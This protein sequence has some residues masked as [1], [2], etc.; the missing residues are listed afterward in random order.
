M[1]INHDWYIY[2]KIII[3]ANKV[4]KMTCIKSKA[5]LKLLPAEPSDLL[6]DDMP[7]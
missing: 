3:I 6:F 1:L 2:N 7:H 4:H 5:I